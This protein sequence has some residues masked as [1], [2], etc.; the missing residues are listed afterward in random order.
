MNAKKRTA[1]TLIELLVVMSLIVVLGSLAV[2]FVPRMSEQQRAARGG[3]LLQQWLITAQNQALRAQAPYGIRFYVDAGGNFHG[4]EA[5]FIMQPD[6]YNDGKLLQPIATDLS[7]LRITD[8]DPGNGEYG[9]SPD[10]SK[11]SVQEGDYL[12]LFGV[13]L[14]HRIGPINA[15]I[16]NQFS[17]TLVSP[18][19]NAIPERIPGE[20]ATQHYRIIRKPRP[21]GDEAL[22]LPDDIIIDF[23]ANNDY[24]NT[25]AANYLSDNTTVES[26][27]IV[28]GPAGNI[29]GPQMGTDSIILWVR[30]VTQKMN[31]GEPTLITI[32][33]R[34]GAIEA[35][36]VNF[37]G[38]DELL[39]PPFPAPYTFTRD[40]R[41]SGG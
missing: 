40:G 14:V 29:I 33:S 17:F 4:I 37:S 18:L 2:M 41:S 22:K 8:A 23:K 28:F 35:H 34:T 36:P 26:Y 13:G 10:S 15:T 27:D 38:Y 9:A 16:P 20:H 21:A 11:W 3:S 1:F 31:E 5:Q 24:G 39:A 6:D 19:Q 32:Y 12:E 7:N 30:D 25:L